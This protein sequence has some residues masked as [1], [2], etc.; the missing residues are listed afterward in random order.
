M[1]AAFT[2]PDVLVLADEGAAD[3]ATRER[4]GVAEALRAMFAEAGRQGGNAF[5]V[6]A[7]SIIDPLPTGEVHAPVRLWYGD[8]DLAIGVEHGRWYA[9]RLTRAELTVVPGAGHLLPLDRWGE[10]LAAAVR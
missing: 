5:D 8:A 7:G 3:A 4:P 10:I 1:M 9:E 2:D 6:V